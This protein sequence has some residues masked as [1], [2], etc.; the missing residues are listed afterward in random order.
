[1]KILSS[2]S[3][4]TLSLPTVLFLGISPVLSAPA[5]SLVTGTVTHNG[6]V[7]IAGSGFGV[8]TPAAPLLWDD[9]EGQTVDHDAAVKSGTQVRGNNPYYDVWPREDLGHWNMRYRGFPFTPTPSVGA[10]RAPH[11][12]SATC[13][14]GGHY[15]TRTHSGVGATP[16]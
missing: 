11:P 2:A 3:L 6:E 1:M 10:I 13:L 8:K 9:G 14:A 15:D 16:P 5:I 7:T 12:R 4:A